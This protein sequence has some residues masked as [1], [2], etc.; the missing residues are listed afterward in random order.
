MAV[1]KKRCAY[2]KIAKPESPNYNTENSPLEDRNGAVG[3]ASLSGIRLP[4]ASHIDGTIREVLRVDTASCICCVA[5]K[6]HTDR[7]QP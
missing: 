2:T 5:F 3:A 1:L 6:I 4:L 7:L